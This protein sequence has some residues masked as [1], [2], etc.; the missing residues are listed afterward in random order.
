[1]ADDRPDLRE[2]AD[3]EPRRRR[4]M[5]EA[6]RVGD[7]GGSDGSGVVD[8]I[9]G[10]R[11][12][13]RRR[14]VEKESKKLQKEREKRKRREPVRRVKSEVSGLREDLSGATGRAASAARTVGAA[15][16]SGADGRP[17]AR[18]DDPVARAGEAAMAGPPVN[19]TL[20]PFGG[21]D[22]AAGPM[23]LELMAG[24]GP[25]E[26][27]ERQRRERGIADLETFAA[28]GGVSF[29]DGGGGDGGPLAIDDD[30]LAVDDSLVFGG[31]R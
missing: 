9:R 23:Q 11:K 18:E 8:R 20:H 15:T 12:R 14:R 26:I 2:A 25:R 17:G 1:M 29:G 3:V 10:L 4:D 21:P 7:A 5:R 22:Q 31:E 27:R 30:P 16:G 6:D 24:G 19:A 28:A 13:V